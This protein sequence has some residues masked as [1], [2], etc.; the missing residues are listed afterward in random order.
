MGRREIEIAEVQHGGLSIV[1]KADYKEH[2]G[3]REEESGEREGERER[4][5]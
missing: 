1:I 2:Q 5:N 4:I 3:E